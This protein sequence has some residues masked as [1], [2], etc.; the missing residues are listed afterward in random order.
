VLTPQLVSLPHIRHNANHTPS[1]PP[2]TTG[3][4]CQVSPWDNPLEK[5]SFNNSSVQNQTREL[6]QVAHT[7]K[8]RQCECRIPILR[9][10]ENSPKPGEINWGQEA[11]YCHGL[12]V[13]NPP[14][15]APSPTATATDAAA[16]ELYP[17]KNLAAT[18]SSTAAMPAPPCPDSPAPA[19]FR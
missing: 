2:P 12:H 5:S 3:R 1:A 16:T 18:T 4:K 19:H 10:F 15:P 8:F 7:Y 9:A 6:C 11:H 14:A 17:A 13:R